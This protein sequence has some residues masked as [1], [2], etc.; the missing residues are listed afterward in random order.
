[1]KRRERGELEAEVM[2]VLWDTD[3]WLTPR[4]VHS[5]VTTPR[6][7]LAY[8]TIMTILVRLWNK[9]MLERRQAGRAFA[10]RPVA[11]R[12]EWTA[13]RMHELLESSGNRFL[14]LNHF[15]DS[16]SARE[17][18]ELRRVLDARRKR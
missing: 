10:Y 3:A 15:A 2:D 5:A 1:M 11:S 18:R 14:T 17:A 16:I 9:E 12:D 6:R 13:E 4:Q 8:T 7:P